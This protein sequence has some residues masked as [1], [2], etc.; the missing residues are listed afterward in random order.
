VRLL[1]ILAL[2]A[3]IFGTVIA[4]PAAFRARRPADLAW[5]LLAPAAA[6]LAIAGLVTI[7]SPSLLVD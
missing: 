7:V 2:A 5:A 4:T 1:G 3:G 6:L